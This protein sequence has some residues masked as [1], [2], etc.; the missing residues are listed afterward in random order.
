[1]IKARI[2]R[3]EI[4]QKTDLVCG[5]EAGVGD[6]SNGQL[7]VVG[8]LGGDDGSVGSKGEVDTGI[9]HQ[10][11]L[12]LGQIDVKSSVESEGC[13]DGGHNLGHESVQVGVGGPLDV[14]VAPA[15]VVDSFI[16]DHEG[17]VRVL[18]G[19]MGGQDR[20][21]GLNNGSRNLGERKMSVMSENNGRPPALTN[22]QQNCRRT[23]MN[24]CPM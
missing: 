16:V 23:E 17:T 19:C 6:L 11:G 21:V 9:G 5:F 13:S 2:K 24:P 20:V 3:T 12:E 8:L 10:V 7:L 1:M 22:E 18:E 4:Q 14:H 15:D